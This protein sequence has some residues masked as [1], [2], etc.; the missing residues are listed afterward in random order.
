MASTTLDLDL[1]ERYVGR[2][3]GMGIAVVARYRRRAGEQAAEQPGNRKL[4]ASIAEAA[5]RSLAARGVEL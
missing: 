5:S 4:Y 2:F 3:A 1:V